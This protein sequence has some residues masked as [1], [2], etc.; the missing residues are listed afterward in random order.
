M[1]DLKPCGTTAAYQRHVR[2]GEEACEPCKEA[3]RA[4]TA[5][6]RATNEHVRTQG[7]KNTR[8]QNRAKQRLVAAY[9]DVYE[10]LLLEEKQRE[11]SI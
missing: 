7:R 9:R 8:A 6:L 3:N 5:M 11:W 1:G 10:V 4:H 2:A